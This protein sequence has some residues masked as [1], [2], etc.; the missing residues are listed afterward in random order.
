MVAREGDIDT[1]A[2]CST[3]GA[4]TSNLRLVLVDRRGT[5]AAL[6]AGLSEAEGRV[7]AITDDDAQ[8]EE[9]WLERIGI[10]FAADPALGALGGPDLPRGAGA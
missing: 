10:E 2:V 1:L 5:V 9:D 8:P 3:A 6:N 7:I 4:Q